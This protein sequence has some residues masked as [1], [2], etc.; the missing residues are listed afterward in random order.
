M[1][2]GMQFRANAL[3]DPNDPTSKPAVTA[4][5][6]TLLGQQEEQRAQQDLQEQ[7]R[8]RSLAGSAPPYRI[9]ANDVLSITVWDHPELISPNLTYSIGPTGADLPA[10]Q[11]GTPP[12]S[13]FSVSDDGYIQFP[14]TGLVKVAGLTE[15]EAQKLIIQRLSAYIRAPQVTLRV[16][17]Y[18]SKRIYIR[19]SVKTPGT[20]ALSG[21]PTTLTSALGAAGGVAESGDES[22]ILLSRHGTNYSINFPEM[23]RLGI[24]PDKIFLQNSDIVYVSPRENN[25]VVVVGEV[26]QPKTVMINNEGNLSLSQALGEAGGVRPDTAAPNAI[27]VI[28]ARKPGQSPEIFHLNSKSPVGL[29]LAENFALQGKDIVYVDTTGLVRWNRLISLI[30]PT[31]TSIYLGQRIDNR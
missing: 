18:L 15:N 1:I 4:V 10:A 26:I 21:V 14:Y 20:L 23:L 22:R 13:G 30:L 5:T 31:A 8:Y 9:E 24:N 25:K 12:L 2:P 29:A 6:P 16:G 17:A 7:E 3:L 28:R 11:L 19:G 27:Y